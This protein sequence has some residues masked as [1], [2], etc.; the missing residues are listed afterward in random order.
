MIKLLIAD[1]HTLFRDGLK[2][3]FAEYPEMLAAGEASS[4]KEVIDKVTK[5][6][7][8]VILLDISMPGRNGIEVIKDLKVLRPHLQVL[9]LSMYS[10]EQYAF[11][12]LKAGAA[13]YLT[14]NQA[15]DELIK[16]IQKIAMGGKYITPSVAEQLAIDLEQDLNMPLHKRLSNREY[17]VMCMIASGKTVNEI[18]SELSLCVS[19][20]STLR[21]RILLKMKMKTNAEI[22]YYAIKNGLVE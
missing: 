22:T 15:S 7:Y 10:E 17:Q 12:A 18:A 8:D 4:G 14:K 3:I 16:A 11:R 9:V 20:I 1:D 6:D 13:G 21:S 19:T 2:Q 5:N